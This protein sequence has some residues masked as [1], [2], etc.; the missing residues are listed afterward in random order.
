MERL[1]EK[2]KMMKGRY[3]KTST[4]DLKRGRRK[5][6]TD[7]ERDRTMGV[8]RGSRRWIGE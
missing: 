1:E 7:Q 4:E 6:G 8:E 3:I 5:E 2:K